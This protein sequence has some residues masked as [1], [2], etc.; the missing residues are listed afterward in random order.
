MGIIP[1]FDKYK[2]SQCQ[3]QGEPKKEKRS[4]KYENYPLK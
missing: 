3:A 1:I 2:V 4:Q